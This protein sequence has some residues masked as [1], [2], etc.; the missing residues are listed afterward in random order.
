M[1]KQLSTRKNLWFENKNRKIQFTQ[2]QDKAC[3][4]PA[5][6]LIVAISGGLDSCVL[7][8]LLFEVSNKRNPL[9]PCYIEHGIRQEQP[10]AMALPLYCQSFGLELST[11]R[12][13]KGWL[14]KE[15]A[16]RG[17]SLE[18]LARQ[19]RYRRLKHCQKWHLKNTIKHGQA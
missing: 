19:E 1:P 14:Q 7:L 8:A 3:S 6:P 13:Q 16:R 10:E 2:L 5:G 15:A 11:Y 4:L 12:I 18:D 17:L 9:L